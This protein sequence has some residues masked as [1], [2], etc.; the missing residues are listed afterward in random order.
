MTVAPIAKPDTLKGGR[1]RSEATMQGG[2]GAC[3][4]ESV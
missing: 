4:H 3:D 2:R 1:K